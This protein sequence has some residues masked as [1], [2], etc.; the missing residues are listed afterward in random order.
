MPQ[1]GPFMS[2][3]KTGANLHDCDAAHIVV[4]NIQQFAG[5]NNRWYEKFPR[6]YFRMILV[7]EGHHNVAES[8]RRLFDYFDDRARGFFYSHT[9]PI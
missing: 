2:E 3:L 1:T 6:D 4:A 8:W 7:D 5:R 9:H